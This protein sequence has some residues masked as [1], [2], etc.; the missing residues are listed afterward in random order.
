[1]AGKDWTQA[2]KSEIDEIGSIIVNLMTGNNAGNF[3]FQ[4]QSDTLIGLI[5]YQKELSDRLLNT[6]LSFAPPSQNVPLPS[7]DNTESN[8][9]RSLLPFFEGERFNY[10]PPKEDTG[11]MLQE[12]FSQFQGLTGTFQ[13][14]KEIGDPLIT[15]FNGLFDTI[16]PTLEQVLIP[17]SDLLWGIGAQLGEYMLPLFEDLAVGVADLA[18]GLGEVLKPIIQAIAHVMIALLSPIKWLGDL[19]G[20]LGRSLQTFM[21]N[22]NPANIFNQRSY[23]TFSS[24]AFTG[25]PDRQDAIWADDPGL[26]TRPRGGPG[27]GPGGGPTYTGSQP[28]TFKFYNQGNVVGSGGMEE[29]ATI[30]N[31]LIQRNARYA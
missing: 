29:L 4:T 13:R 19:F 8:P 10:T 9:R 16:G 18:K 7:G 27:G 25:I 23:E 15:M 17:I 11:N 24:D 5:R 2:V 28:I 12:F 20:W 22:L 21:Y 31:N 30:I 3:Q 14:M 1:V 6:G 26:P